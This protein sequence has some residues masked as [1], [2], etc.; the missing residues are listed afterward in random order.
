MLAVNLVETKARLLDGHLV[1]RKVVRLVHRMVGMMVGD[2]VG[3]LVAMLVVTTV[4]L[5]IMQWGV[6]M[7]W[8]TDKL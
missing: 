4:G 1:L 5:W 8:L 7:V 3:T 6:L 2:G